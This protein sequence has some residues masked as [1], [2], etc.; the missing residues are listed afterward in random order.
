MSRRYDVNSI[1]LIVLREI[2]KNP[3]LRGG[4]L[5][6]SSRQQWHWRVAFFQRYDTRVQITVRDLSPK[7]HLWAGTHHVGYIDI[8]G[9]SKE[10]LRRELSEGV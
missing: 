6:E 4:V 2:A 3:H 1:P 5:L 9:I 7:S 10:L 8:N